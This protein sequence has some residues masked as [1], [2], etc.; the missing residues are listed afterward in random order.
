MNAVLKLENYSYAY[1]G[2][3]DFTLKDINLEISAGQCLCLTG[4]T[5]SGKTTLVLAIKGLLTPG[6]E[7]GEIIFSPGAY[8]RRHI[9]VLLQNPETQVLMATVGEEV[10]FGLHNRG[11]D[12]GL[13]PEKVKTALDA[14]GLDYPL[15]FSTEKLSAGNKY[16]L[17]LA[18]L[19]AMS[20]E[21]MIIDEPIAQLDQ[22][23]HEKLISIIQKLKSDGVSFFICEHHPEYLSKIVD[24]YWY[25]SKG[26][27]M[28]SEAYKKDT[29]FEWPQPL[30]NPCH[31]SP[32]I[33]ENKII[34]KAR[35]VS[36]GD[37][38]VYIWE[39][40]SFILKK[41]DRCFVCGPNGEGKSVLLRCMTGFLKPVAGEMLIFGERPVPKDLRGRVG[42]LTQNPPKQLFET[43]VFEEV[44][45]PL[46]RLQKERHEI[47]ARV[48]EILALCGISELANS[49]PHKLSYG[50]KH[51]VALASILAPGPELLLLDDPF[52]GLDRIRTESILRLLSDLSR[53]KK[54]TLV[55]TSHH[56]AALPDIADVTLY[57]KG[58]KIVPLYTKSNIC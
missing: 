26:K 28:P 10:A 18:S 1:P 13:I 29:R 34:V 8:E 54:M 38:N 43:S 46:K 39:D 37:N 48:D 17:I 12:E 7:K 15:D 30:E 53:Q 42:Y 49:S 24:S 52:A 27:I 5:G 47:R 36:T 22:A 31:S 16:R 20:P 50:Q 3:D 56:P 19:L 2:N 9:A 23:G 40:A 41:G 32:A 44:S 21:L 45:F 55:W 35:D 57:V 11:V 51:L 4:D 6:N 14:V 33:D 25:L 58:G